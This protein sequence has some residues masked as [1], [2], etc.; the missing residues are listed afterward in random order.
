MATGNQLGHHIQPHKLEK[1]YRTVIRRPDIKAC[2]TSGAIMAVSD[3]IC[4]RIVKRYEE[5]AFPVTEESLGVVKVEK[6]TS[7]EWD[8]SRTIHFS[9]VGL[10]LHG[11]LFFNG[12]KWLDNTFG[13]SKTVKV[14]LAKTV[15]GQV[16]WLL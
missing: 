4:Q 1:M 16:L 8:S 7:H 5:N 3:F 10:T 6:F 14:A 9:L 13:A 12:F 2:L 15:L 11:P